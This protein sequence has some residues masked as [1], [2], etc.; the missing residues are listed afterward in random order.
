MT[1]TDDLSA[2]LE[3][4]GYVVV[5]RIARHDGR[6]VISTFLDD[7][8]LPDEAGTRDELMGY[9][10]ANNGSISGKAAQFYPRE[11]MDLVSPFD[12]VEDA[13][14][15]AERFIADS[16]A[17]A[18]RGPSRPGVKVVTLELPVAQV[19]RRPTSKTGGGKVAC[20]LDADEIQI[21]DG[22]LM[23]ARCINAWL[24]NG[25]A[26]DSRA[27]VIRWLVALVRN[28]IGPSC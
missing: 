20:N 9:V 2:L 13:V 11:C 28:Q 26:V 15:L 12:S 24:P 8:P 10:L 17:T 27:D 1:T 18:T 19:E 4:H 21:L 3:R 7:D 23:A 6:R 22:V 14:A 5:R 16:I 25:A